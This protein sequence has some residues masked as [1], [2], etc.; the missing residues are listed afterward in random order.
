MPATKRRTCSS[1]AAVGGGSVPCPWCSPNRIS[2]AARPRRALDLDDRGDL[3]PLSR[4][5]H[6]QV[7]ARQ[8]LFQSTNLFLGRPPTPHAVRDRRGRLRRR[9]QSTSARVLRALL[10]RW[11]SHPRVDLITTDGFL[12]PTASSSGAAS[13]IARGTPSLRPA[14]AAA[15]RHRGQV[16]APLVRAPVY[17]HTSTTSSPASTSRCIDRTSSCQGLNVLQTGRLMVS[18]LFDSPV[19]RRT[20]RRHREVVRRA[21]PRAPFHV[22]LRPDSHFAHYADLPDQAAP[23]AREIW[24]SINRPN[25]VENILPTRPARRSCCARTPITRF[26]GCDCARSDVPAPPAP[27]TC[28]PGG[29]PGHSRTLFAL[30]PRRAAPVDA[31]FS[32]MVH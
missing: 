12:P 26:S 31:H 2:R 27:G 8:R 18:D 10:T 25:L 5:I 13:C 7:S 11:D 21:F 23:R 30:D 4:L 15:V 17:S 28:P 16:R 3:S 24:T 22:V 29:R 19:C 14:G 20:Y 1:T 32:Q 9:G 6:L